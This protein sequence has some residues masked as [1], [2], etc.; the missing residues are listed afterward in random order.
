MFI[1]LA[2]VP[3]SHHS[4]LSY[5]DLTEAAGLTVHTLNP[6]VLKAEAD[7]PLWV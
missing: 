1:Q 4:N 2:L 5:S 7:G 6:S 3:L